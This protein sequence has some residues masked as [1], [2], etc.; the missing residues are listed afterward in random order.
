MLQII[1]ITWLHNFM[2]D[3]F[4]IFNLFYIIVYYSEEYLKYK[5]RFFF[6]NYKNKEK[7]LS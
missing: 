4:L 2:D 7:T 3:L 1:V 5:I 6:E